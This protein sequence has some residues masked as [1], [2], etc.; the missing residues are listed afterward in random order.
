MPTELRT[1]PG[2][3]HQRKPRT[4]WKCAKVFARPAN[5]H[6]H[7]QKKNKCDKKSKKAQQEAREVASRLSSRVHYLK[8]KL[9]RAGG[10]AVDDAAKA[11]CEDPAAALASAE[12]L[13][14]VN[15]A[16]L[17]DLC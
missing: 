7:L 13:A 11:A 8:K 14:K 2:R 1:Q 12:A 17:V 6:R 16:D 5:L 10:L 3:P 15:F 4:C 9:E